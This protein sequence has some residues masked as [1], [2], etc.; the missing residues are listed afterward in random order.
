MF[1]VQFTQKIKAKEYHQNLEKLFLNFGIKNHLFSSK[2]VLLGL[3]YIPRQVSTKD[4]ISL[5]YPCL[6]KLLN[7]RV[8]HF[9]KAS[10]ARKGFNEYTYNQN[11]R[12]LRIKYVYIRLSNPKAMQH[13]KVQTHLYSEMVN[14]KENTISQLYKILRKKSL[15]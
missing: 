6:S 12:T 14:N 1:N 7:A 13:F 9:N 4:S 15:R 5:L 11:S 3:K 10:P 8:T 2:I